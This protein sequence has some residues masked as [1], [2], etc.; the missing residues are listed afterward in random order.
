MKEKGRA[1]LSRRRAIALALSAW[2]LVPSGATAQARNWPSQSPPRPLR[3]RDVKFPPY[4]LTTLANG[5]QVVVV[6]H[7][8]QPAVSLRMIVKAG[9]AQD[10]VGK[11]GLAAMLASLLDQGTTTRR[12]QEVADTIDSVGGSL[13]TGVG[14]DLTFTDV[15]V[16]KDSFDVGMGLLAD[17]IRNPAVATEEVERQRQQIESGL[18][19]SGQDPEYVANVVFDRLVYGFNPY[20]YPGNGTPESVTSITRDDLVAYHRRY[21]APNNSLLAVVGDITGAEALA[22]VERAFGDWARQE[23]PAEKVPDPPQPTR[24]VI[25][26]DKPDAVQTEIR[27]GQLGIPRKHAD[28]TPLDLA[29][30]VLGGEGANRLHRILR[31]ERGLTYGA[32]A[33]METLK[34][35]G[36]IV[37]ETST[38]SEATGEVLRLI[39]DELSRLRR[40]R[41]DEREL[42]DAKA[43]LTGNF[44]LTLE[45]PDDIATHV[46]NHLFYDLPLDELQ[47]FRQKVNAVTLG[48]VAR[49]AWGY[50]KPDRLSVVLVGN[51]AVFADTLRG[52]GFGRYERI[53]LTDLDLL[54]ADFKK[55]AP[56]PAPVDK[57]Q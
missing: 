35:N 16:M 56:K 36:Q 46:L 13:E 49:V 41:V 8:E 43:Y 37:V 21:F 52:V 47:T 15:V 7:T 29:I 32:S 26:L 5:M 50:L 19:V 54:A 9:T 3:A 45:T 23:I 55:P 48:D 51:A 33:N 42:A 18:A 28:Y 4:Q 2:L 38:R 53:A 31:T 24:R 11:P 1:G 12:A 30:R 17:V 6:I 27:V 57:R 34:R 44:P 25:V 14:R 39:V 22:A 20:G 40:E 10:P